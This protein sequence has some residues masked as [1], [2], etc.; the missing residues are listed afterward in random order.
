MPRGI[1]RRVTIGV[2]AIVALSLA[3]M[4][5]VLAFQRRLPASRFEYGVT[6]QMSGVLRRLPY[7][8][9]ERGDGRVWLVGE[10][11]FGA[12]ASLALIADGGATV[13]GSIIQRGMHTMLEVH[14]AEPSTIGGEARRGPL[15]APAV[16]EGAVVTLVGE[17]VDTKCFLGVMNPSE[18]AVHRDCAVRCLSGGIPPAL[19]VRDGAGRE[20]LVLLVSQTGGEMA[21]RLASLAGQ[22][23]EVNGRLLRDGPDLLLYA[24]REA[25]RPG[26]AR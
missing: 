13:R 12:A 8:V 14:R 1:R 6:R 9:L 10:G 2:A 15:P 4:T 23:V 22:I 11:K 20:A 17:I 18:G 21:T 7:P 3:V 24:D 5:L 19:A 26:G 25:Y 16:S